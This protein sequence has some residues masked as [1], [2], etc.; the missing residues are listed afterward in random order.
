MRTQ[1]EHLLLVTHLMNRNF[2]SGQLH[3]EHA[4]PLFQFKVKQIKTCQLKSPSVVMQDYQFY[5]AGKENGHEV[6]FMSEH[7][8]DNLYSAV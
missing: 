5:F 3:H 4:P 6:N 2:N 8:P 1:Y 7:R